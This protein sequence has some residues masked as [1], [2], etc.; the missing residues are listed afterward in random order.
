M[1]LKE[2]AKEAGVSISTVSR[3]INQSRLNAASLE[4]QERIW[5]IVRRTGYMP[6]IHAQNLR[7]ASALSRESKTHNE[8]ACVF[9]RSSDTA[10]DSFFPE[11][12][13]A[14]EK[15]A[16]K[17][18]Y[19]V[20]YFFTANDIT[21]ENFKNIIETNPIKG[22]AVLGRFDRD[23]LSFI[24]ES[25]NSVVY[26]GLNDINTNKH[27]QVI[28]N[29]YQASMAA[30]KYL[31]E[32]GHRKIAYIGERTKEN[33]YRGYF[34]AMQQYSLPLDNR[35]IINAE[36]SPNGGYKG[37]YLLMRQ[38]ANPTAV[39][40]A[41]D[42]TA[43]GVIKALKEHGLRIPNDISVIGI[44]NIEIAQYVSP[45]LTT[46]HIPIDELGKT[47]ARIL[48]DRI[49]KKHHLPLRVEMPFYIVKRES[50]AEPRSD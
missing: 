49:E 19:I 30:I 24:T 47:A 26:V 35:C 44:D 41:S 29:G 38:K 33:R 1:T 34:D 8:L 7:K 21:D 27:D 45:M 23:N 42:A 36:L 22:L 18:N 16:F 46:I 15:E 14:F 13:K 25:C 3:V 10:T 4:V 12:A 32:L 9:A 2:I 37:A 50:C 31:Y 6:N 48:I 20:K 28:C 39:F 43:V 5:K 17:N 11:L 40:C